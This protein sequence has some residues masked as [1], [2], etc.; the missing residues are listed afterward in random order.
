MLK[1]VCSLKCYLEGAIKICVEEWYPT[2]QKNISNDDDGTMVAGFAVMM[3]A[4]IFSAITHHH[5]SL[6]CLAMLCVFEPYLYR[7]RVNHKH[8]LPPTSNGSRA[9]AGDSF[10]LFTH[11]RCKMQDAMSRRINL[12]SARL[13]LQTNTTFSYVELAI[14]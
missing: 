12:R 7:V 13:L 14:K 10:E 11:A 6:L 8:D 5:H 1:T 9:M 2:I 4:E 3:K